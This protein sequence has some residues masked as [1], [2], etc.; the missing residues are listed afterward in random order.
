MYQGMN[1][2]MYLESKKLTKEEWQNTEVRE[3]AEKRVK[4]GLVLAELSK[5]EK[6]TA[7]DEELVLKVNEYQAQYGN[8]SGQDFTSPELQRDI[9]NRL[10]TDKTID[11]LLALNTK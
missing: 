5:V 8:K 3:A 9:A 4:A 2:D 11:L 6:V 7:T 10:L 1:L